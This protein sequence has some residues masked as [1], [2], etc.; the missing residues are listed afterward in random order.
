MYAATNIDLEEAALESSLA[1]ETP[2]NEKRHTRFQRQEKGQ[3]P[4][5][6]IS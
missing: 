1:E 3:N 2:L 6:A 5:T 4:T